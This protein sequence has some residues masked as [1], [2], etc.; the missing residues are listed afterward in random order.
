M[1]RRGETRRAWPLA[2]TARNIMPLVPL[3][4]GLGLLASLLE[5]AGIG[6]LIPLLTILLAS[7]A[8]NA[9]P[10]PLRALAPIFTRVD[11]DDRAFILAGAILSLILLK[12][13]VQVANGWLVASIDSQI[14]SD[15]RKGIASSLLAVEYPF[16]LEQDAA[17]LTRIAANDSWFVVQA[18]R[19]ALTLVPAVAGLLV[20]GAL[21][22]L[23]NVKLFLI[24]IVGA[25]AVQGLVYA[26][27]LRQRQ[28]SHRTTESN[29]LLMRRLL[30]LLQAPRVVRLFNQQKGEE[31]RAGD[32]I[33]QVSRR[34]RASNLLNALVH[35]SVDVLVALLFLAVLLIGYWSGMSIPEIT[36]FLLLMT[37]A[38]P[39]AKAIT[40]A[41][42][43]MASYDGAVREVDWLTSQTGSPKLAQT[44]S[45]SLDRPISFEEVR[46]AYPNGAS[47]LDGLSCI[48]RPGVAT[49]LLGESAAGK[50][51]LV[52]LLCRLLEPQ[53]GEIRAGPDPISAFDAESWR[54][55]I[56]VAGQ[57]NDLVSGT[58]REN[59]AY[60]RP[61]ATDAEVEAVARAVGAHAFIEALPQAYETLVGP[62]GLNLSGGQRQRIGVARALLLEPDL[63]V[64]DEAVS[65]V[66]ALS[67]AEIVKLALE[68]RNFRTLVIIS[69]RKT[70]VAACE[71]GIVLAHGKVI[72]AGPLESLA[73]YRMMGG[74][75][76]P[77]TG[78]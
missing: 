40:G 75:E 7:D 27:E 61:E 1:L 63:L 10:G 18:A 37:R 25:G 12:G 65:A 76:T 68:H 52:N 49:A 53:S 77:P 5:G 3:V 9:L 14:G 11:A 24:V 20:F 57:D 22:A 56:A 34:V 32:A 30:T 29:R 35:P 73:Y 39:H 45:P 6:L 60:G 59:I 38:Q 67:D 54:R 48:I 41:R 43:A 26:F 15:I 72:E 70:T 47:G 4:A 55:R 17:R 33:E 69:H 36:A 78:R 66:D 21:L 28:L 44:S 74:D 58:V 31:E 64:L 46:F 13:V 62:Q 51:T 2:R 8:S 50:T 71:H 42:L 16:F 19:S 23:L